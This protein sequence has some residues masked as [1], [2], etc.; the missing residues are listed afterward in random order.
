MVA[1]FVIQNILTSSQPT[2]QPTK[3]P[4]NQETNHPTTYHPT[5]QITIQPKGWVLRQAE[6]VPC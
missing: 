5:N 6:D 2:N 4:R 1:S 3:K